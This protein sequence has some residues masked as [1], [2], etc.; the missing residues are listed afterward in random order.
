MRLDFWHRKPSMKELHDAERRGAERYASHIHLDEL[1]A[2]LEETHGE[3]AR[4]EATVYSREGLLREALAY[5]PEGALAECI[6]A[7][8]GP[9]P[10]MT[11]IVA[12]ASGGFAEVSYAAN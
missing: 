8:I 4:L 10:K 12:L 7:A 9:A 6:A 3:I 5:V 2:S 1:R 11:G